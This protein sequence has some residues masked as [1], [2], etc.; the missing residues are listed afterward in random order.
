MN[1]RKHRIYRHSSAGKSACSWYAQFFTQTTHF[2][3]SDWS[4]SKKPL[5]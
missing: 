4:N 2:F 5:D 3:I 1:K